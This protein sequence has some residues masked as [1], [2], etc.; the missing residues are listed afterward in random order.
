[1]PSHLFLLLLLLLLPPEPFGT[2]QFF[3]GYLNIEEENEAQG[4]RARCF[5]IFPLLINNVLL[6]VAVLWCSPAGSRV[7]VVAASSEKAA[8]GLGKHL[9]ALYLPLF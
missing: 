7:A 8:S 3:R 4:S 9:L 6:L 2:F 5:E 1:M